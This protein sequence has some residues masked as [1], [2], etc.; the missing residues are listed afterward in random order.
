MVM[1]TEVDRPTT[2]L[3]EHVRV[4]PAVSSVRL[5][6]AHPVEDAIADSGS[7]TLQFAATALRYQPLL[8]SVPVI[9]GLI[10]GGVGSRTCTI[11]SALI[12]IG[13]LFPCASVAMLKKPYVWPGTP[14]KFTD[15]AVV[16]AW[17]GV[18]GPPLSDTKISKV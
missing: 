13:S 17:K 11:I 7:D 14:L 4:T 15:V 2:L 1:G 16:A 3:A 8:P 6:G 18:N 9:W 5:V 12:F 10:T